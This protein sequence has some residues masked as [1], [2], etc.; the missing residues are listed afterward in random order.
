[1]SRCLPFDIDVDVNVTEIAEKAKEAGDKPVE[2]QFH[3]IE[4][5]VKSG[6]ATALLMSAAEVT[7]L[8]HD[9]IKVVCVVHYLPFS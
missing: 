1:M 4:N 5:A 8:L 2:T 6:N 3:E 9:G 7:F